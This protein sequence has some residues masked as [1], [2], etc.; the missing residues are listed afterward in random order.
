MRVWNRRRLY[1]KST[2]QKPILVGILHVFA[3]AERG[4]GVFHAAKA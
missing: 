3:L 1:G 4:S 2:G